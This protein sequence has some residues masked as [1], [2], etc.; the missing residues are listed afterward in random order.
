MYTKVIYN[1]LNSNDFSE[2]VEHLNGNSFLLSLLI[3]NCRVS[4]VFIDKK[5]LC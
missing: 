5:G 2:T 1:I 3:L 4:Q